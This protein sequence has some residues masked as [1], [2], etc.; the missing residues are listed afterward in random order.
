MAVIDFLTEDTPTGTLAADLIGLIEKIPHAPSRIG[1]MG[2][3][4]VDGL[5][6]TT[7]KFDKTEYGLELVQTSARGT[8]ATKQASLPRDMVHFEAVR[9]AKEVKV[10]AD[11]ALNLRRLGTEGDVESV[12]TYLTQKARPTVGSVRATLEFHR[13][14]ALKGLVLDANGAVI[15]NLYTKMG[16]TA[17]AKIYFDFD[18]ASPAPGAI[19]KICSNIVRKIA[20]ELGGLPFTGVHAFVGAEF[21][22]KIANHPETRETFLNQAQ[23]AELRGG[24]AFTTFTY[25]GIVFEEYRGLIGATAFVEDVEAAFFPVGVSGLFKQMFAPADRL[26]YAGTLGLAEYALPSID[27]KGRFREIEIQA[28]PITVCTRPGVLLSGDAGAEPAPVV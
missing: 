2:L 28:N 24:T 6:T 16:V 13:V 21:M 11:E 3:F 12:E 17:P 15:E 1:D 7:A 19:R 22:D 8:E 9:V 25:G 14:G 20:A 4:E 23:A 10:M 5:M 27:P 26:D 18:N